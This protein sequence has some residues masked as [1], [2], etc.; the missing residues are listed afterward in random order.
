MDTLQIPAPTNKYTKV[1]ITD[2]ERPLS[3]HRNTLTDPAIDL[4][5]TKCMD[6]IPNPDLESTK[7]MDILPNTAIDLESTK[8]MDI[9]PN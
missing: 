4:E 7:W 2:V 3:V 9:I 8:C 1:N 6:I 5:S